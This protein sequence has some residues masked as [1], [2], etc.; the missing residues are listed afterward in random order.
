LVGGGAR[1]GACIGLPRRG[2]ASIVY[3]GSNSFRRQS[4][5]RKR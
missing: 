5:R 1:I 2:A 3:L 4:W